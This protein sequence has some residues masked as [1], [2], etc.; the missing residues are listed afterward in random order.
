MFSLLEIEIDPVCVI[1]NGPDFQGLRAG[2]SYWLLS[3]NL[4]TSSTLLRAYDSRFFFQTSMD[5]MLHPEKTIKYENE[6]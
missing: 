5:F 1:I 3:P 2:V 4:S 6:V